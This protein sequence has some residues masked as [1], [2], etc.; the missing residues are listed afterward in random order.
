MNQTQFLTN[1]YA[2]TDEDWRFWVNGPHVPVTADALP[3]RSIMKKQQNT[4]KLTLKLN[5]ER[6]CCNDVKW[7][8]SGPTRQLRSNC[9]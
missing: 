8:C 9:L 7:H 1:Q 2:I 5:R 6:R 4:G 3:D